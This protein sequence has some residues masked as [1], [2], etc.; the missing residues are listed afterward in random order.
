MNNKGT[1]ALFKSDVQ[2]VK[3]L[4]KD[5]SITVSTTDIDGVK[6]LGLPLKA[7]LSPMVD[8]PYERADSMAKRLRVGRRSLRYKG[9]TVAMLIYMFIQIPLTLLSLMQAKIGLKTLYRNEVVDCVKN[10]DLVI[11]HSDESFKETASLLPLNFTWAVTWWSML[12]SRTCEILVA[13]S[14][15]KPVVMF[16]NSVGP[17]RTFVGRWLGRLSLNR[18]NCLLIRDPISYE[19]TEKLGIYSPMILTYDTALLFA[20]THKT[21]S[22]EFSKP[23]VGVSPGMYSNSLSPNELNNY[24]LAHSSAIDRSIEEHGLSVAFLP[25]YVS[26]FR[27]DDMEISKMILEKMRHKDAATI[28]ETN[29]VDEFKSILDQMDMII[30]SKMHPAVL[31]ASGYVPILCIA[32]DHKQTG[33]FARLNM[34][35]CTIGIRALSSQIMFEKI[36]HVWNNRDRI[37]ESLR[38]TIPLWQE[39]VKAAIRQAMTPYVKTEKES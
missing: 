1:Q 38:N 29:D 25:H 27:L 34:K 14:F 2:V 9:L 11:S 7:I 23:V 36:N 16:P 33:F 30:T 12:L 15:G 4:V 31:G 20:A 6:R 22:H 8:I 28:I 37:S 5:A 18:C 21:A 13:R 32:Y 19:I 26:G 39:R 3:E 10:C 17:F 35:D 24:I